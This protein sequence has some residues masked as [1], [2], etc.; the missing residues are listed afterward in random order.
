[1]S[2]GADW[3]QQQQQ[4]EQQQYTEAQLQE[5]DGLQHNSDMDEEDER[6]LLSVR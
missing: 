1:M 3:W 5:L 2:D 6:N 4:L